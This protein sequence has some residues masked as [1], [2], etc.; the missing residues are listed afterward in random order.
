MAKNHEKMKN[1]CEKWKKI[2]KNE[3]IVRKQKKL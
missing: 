3:K 1:N 2:A